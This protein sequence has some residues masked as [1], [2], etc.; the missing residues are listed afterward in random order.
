ML[1]VLHDTMDSGLPVFGMNC[2]RLGFLMNHY[3]SSELPERLAAAE[4]V[5][6]HPLRMTAVG[7]DGVTSESLAINEVSL[8]R[9]T[10]NAAH[11]GIIVD[12]KRQLEQLVCDGV[13]LATPAGSTAYN[14][15]A[16]GPI[17]PLGAGLMALTPISPF[18]PRRWRGRCWVSI[19]MLSSKFW[20]QISGQS[21]S[22]LT[23]PNFAKSNRSASYR[24]VISRSI[25]SMTPDFPLPTGQLP[26]NS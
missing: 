14:L 21:V 16:H 2:G 24:R 26:N 8:I 22:A 25:C 1:R 10:H 12:D 7:M 17:I 19:R 13:L 6:L 5:P 3:A 9:Q 15:S 20:S 4:S 23:A 18:R 11:I